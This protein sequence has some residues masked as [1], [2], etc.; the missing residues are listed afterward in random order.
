MHLGPELGR[1]N[2][3]ISLNPGLNYVDLFTDLRKYTV[4]LLILITTLTS[5]LQPAIK[6]SQHGRDE[7]NDDCS[8][9]GDE[10]QLRW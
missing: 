3:V 2:Q 6:P 1:R 4:T 8:R 5:L 7:R 10:V 9:E